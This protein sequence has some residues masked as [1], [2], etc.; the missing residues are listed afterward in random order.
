MVVQRFSQSVINSGILRVYTACGFFMTSIFFIINSSIFS[1]IEMVTWIVLVTVAFKAVG[2]V[3]LS[4][5]ILLFNLDNKRS[6]ID[7]ERASAEIDNILAEF[8]VKE[9]NKK[10]SK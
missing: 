4:L 10:I 2:N 6:E 1:P 7:F 3:M 8:S 5:I 9:T